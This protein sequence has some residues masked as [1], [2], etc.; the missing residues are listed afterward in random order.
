MK[1]S[2]LLW[3]LAYP[4]Y[5]LIGTVRH[6]AGHAVVAWLEGYPITKFVFWPTEGRWGYVV[7][8][9]PVAAISLFGPY[10]LDLLT[11]LVALIVVTQGRFRRHWLWINVV[12]LGMLSPFINSLYNYQGGLRGGSN[13]VGRLLGRWPPTFVHGY[14]LVTLALYLGGVVWALITKRTP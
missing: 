3:V 11:F 1:K 13:D 6:E 5:Q 14:F 2:D 7:W 10:V 12:I 4:L 9:G 8:D